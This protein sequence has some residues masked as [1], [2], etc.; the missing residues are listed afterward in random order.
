MPDIIL[1]SGSRARTEMLNHAG[2]QYQAIP[3]AIDETAI[4]TEL[5][6][7]AVSPEDI[8]AT[9]AQQKALH[10]AK[11]NNDALVIGSDQILECEGKL[12]EKAA[13]QNAARDK[14]K[15]LRGK[16]HRLL[17]S[18]CV[19]SDT[20]ILWQ[21]TD[22]ASLTMRNFDDE[23]L[24][25]YINKAGDDAMQCVGGYALEK[26]GI[27]LFS[28]ISGS[29][30]TILGMPFLPLLAYLQDEQGVKL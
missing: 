7:T 15:I 17:S 4:I 27:T 20:K 6:Q 23:F 5:M 18:V 1:A 13:D 24:E 28:D 26:A 22:T 8:A 30:H 16:T 29:Y 14:L 11:E 25:R 19:A 12:Y 21:T 9:L 10:I 2:I 3:A